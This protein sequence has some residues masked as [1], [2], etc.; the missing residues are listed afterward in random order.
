[1]IFFD[2]PASSGWFPGNAIH[3][4]RFRDNI[5]EVVSSGNGISGFPARREKYGIARVGS[6]RLCT[7]L[8]IKKYNVPVHSQLIRLN[9]L[10]GGNIFPGILQE[11]SSGNRQ[12]LKPHLK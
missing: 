6:R 8:A 3:P 10:A 11:L 5:S 12:F 4:D 1:L 2:Y 9:R 7:G